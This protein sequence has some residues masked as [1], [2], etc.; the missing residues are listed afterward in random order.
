MGWQL[1]LMAL[2]ALCA[3]E[4]SRRDFVLAAKLNGLDLSDLEKKKAAKYWA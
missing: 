4:L 1:A 3:G 2:A